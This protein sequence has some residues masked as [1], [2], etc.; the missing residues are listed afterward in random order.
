MGFGQALKGVKST[1]LGRGM[2]DKMVLESG[3]YAVLIAGAMPS[4]AASF[5]SWRIRILVATTAGYAVYYLVRDNLPMAAPSIIAQYHFTNTQWG[6]LLSA[7]TIVYAFS[8]FTSG[9]LADVLSPRLL[10]P[11]GLALSAAANIAFGLAGGLG[12]FTAFWMLNSVF[13]G[14][15]VPPCARLL[16]HWYGP[17][18][19]GRAWG[20]WN[21]SHQIGGALISV[22]AGFLIVHF[23]WRSAFLVPA[24]VAILMA[25]WLPGRLAGSPRSLGLPSV[26]EFNSGSLSSE[27]AAAVPRAPFLRIF[28]AH[29]LTNGGVWIVSGANFFIYVVR[30]GILSWSPKYLLEAKHLTL[31]KAGVC[32]MAFEIAG[33]AG[34]YVCGW[35]SDTAFK[36]RRGPVS[37]LSMAALTGMVLV[38]FKVTSPNVFLLATIFAGLGFLVYGPQMLVAVAA[39]D[40]ST[41]AASASAVGLTGLLGYFGATFC[42]MATGILVDH[43]GWD[44]AI[45]LYAL[46]AAVGTTLLATT[47]NKDPKSLTLQ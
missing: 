42:G 20:V 2:K 4:P 46:C 13:S 10:L 40:F 37:T 9:L 5:R 33:M 29:V 21:S 19:I 34:A 1:K 47:W 7:A 38:L 14:V 6:G 24:V 15:G 26:E 22:A 31:V 27:P 3:A 30:I 44:S 39:T 16:T 45:A 18:E 41:P 11:L 25:L 17:R 12:A 28:T 43:A 8:K 23:G 36:G 35:L 32:V